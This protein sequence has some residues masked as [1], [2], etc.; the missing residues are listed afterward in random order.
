MPARY[1]DRVIVILDTG[2]ILTETMLEKAFNGIGARRSPG[3][4]AV[5]GD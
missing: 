2:L 1:D 3:F 4:G 5:I